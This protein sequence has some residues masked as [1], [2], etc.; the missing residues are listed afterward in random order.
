MEA[1]NTVST[2]KKKTPGHIIS[3]RTAIVTIAILLFSCTAGWIATEIFPPD[4]PYRR[5]VL[6]ERWG[7]TALSL[8]EALKL[9]DP[10]HSFWFSGVLALFFVVL[11]LCLATRWKGML[12]RSFRMVVPDEPVAWGEGRPG[13]EINVGEPAE[14][15]GSRDPVAHYGRKYGHREPISNE[16]AA[17]ILGKVR[18]AFRSRG[19]AFASRTDGG[20]AVFAAVAGRLRHLGNLIFH[21]G[22]LVI[23]IGGVVG[24]RMGGSEILYGK[25]G[26]ELPL[27]SEGEV[28]RIEDFRILMSGAVQVS[29]YI[30]T[31]KL[32]DSSGAVVDSAKIEVNHPFSYRGIRVYQ[33]TYYLAENEFEWARVKVVPPGR[34]MPVELLL[35][36]GREEPVPGTELSMR[37]GRFMPDFRIIDGVPRSVSGSMNNPALEIVLSGPDKRT[38]GWI[39]LFYPDFG[40]RFERLDALTLEDMEP[41]YYTGLEFTRNP[42]SA[43]F[44][45]GIF[46]GTAGLILLYLFDYR[47]VH[48]RIDGFKLTVSGVTARWTVS[49]RD[50][51]EKIERDMIDA[52]EPGRIS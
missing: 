27:A 38:S 52:I 24:S 20:G 37:A 26:D 42:G 44:I 11:L 47:I 51:L 31:I 40:T 14:W 2:R 41:V 25:V 29:D 46:L 39:F 15:S 22:L 21:A 19:Y 3:Q 23:T 16:Q 49:F 43:L 8:V 36:P 18:K 1:D 12:T 10:F 17:I 45:A 32:L 5:E 9:Y 7:D 30:T 34:S 48:G 4:L 13:F 50:Q 35:R 33:S 6:R 28:L